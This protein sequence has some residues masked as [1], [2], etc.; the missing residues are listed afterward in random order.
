MERFFSTFCHVADYGAQGFGL[1]PQMIET[2]YPLVLWAPPG[3][4]VN[5]YYRAGISS[6][7]PEKLIEYIEK[8]FVHIIGRERWLLDEQYRRYYSTSQPFATWHDN[9]DGALKSIWHTQQS[10]PERQR[11]VFLAP[12]EDGWEWAKK[13]LEEE[14]E[15]M[16]PVWERI[17]TKRIP[18]VSQ[19]RIEQ[20]RGDKEKS[21]LQVLRDARNHTK[22]IRD[23]DVDLP[24]LL[25]END[26]KFFAFLE[27]CGANKLP[28]RRRT[29]NQGM[30]SH[31]AQEAHRLLERFK[32]PEKFSSLDDF[33]GSEAHKDMAM[34]LRS[35]ADMAQFYW[36]RQTLR[37]FMLK[38]L[39]HDIKQGQRAE[40]LW[41][42]VGEDRIEK[43]VNVG[44]FITGIASLFFSSLAF[45]PST[46][47]SI[48]GL[49]L[50]VVPIVT[51]ISQRL[52][53][54]R[55][56]YTGPQWPYLVRF[57]KTPKRRDIGEVRAILDALIA[58]M[59]EK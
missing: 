20:Y 16:D 47:L 42:I 39:E 48:G 12:E 45:D 8:G 26:G 18:L 37:A 53:I 6:I 46:T 34:W 57:N 30:K 1:I 3:A 23:V 14:P 49:I 22:A 36:S 5:E 15:R 59:D 43:V 21:V 7:S 9:F 35:T 28:P 2:S 27:K 33:V 17:K 25:H 29:A 19:K 13:L 58:D 51:G 24:F 32:N 10:M 56:N 31:F 4:R 38:Q 50:N 52:G 54:V 44:G 40:D 41:D 55:A 11:S